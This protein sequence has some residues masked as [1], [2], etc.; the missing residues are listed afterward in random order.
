MRASLVSPCPKHNSGNPVCVALNYLM[1]HSRFAG[2]FHKVSVMVCM[3]PHWTEA[4][5]Y[6]RTTASSVARILLEE[7]IP[8]WG[9]LLEL[10]GDRG[11]RLT[12]QVL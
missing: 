7:T 4:F 11:P 8:T 10:H 1:G 2:E 5:P 3:F 12:S 9:T 6:R